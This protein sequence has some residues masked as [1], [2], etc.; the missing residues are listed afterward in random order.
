MIYGVQARAGRAA[1][2]ADRHRDKWVAFALSLAVPGAGQLWAGRASCLAD[3]ALAAGLIAGAAIG[4]P[5]WVYR[6]GFVLLAILSAERAKRAL[7]VVP[8]ERPGPRPRAVVAD[9][10]APGRGIDLLITLDLARPAEEVWDAMADPTRF[11]TIDPFHSRVIVMEGS[12]RPGAAIVLEHRAFG[13][14]FHRF[15]KLLSWREGN[16]Y[17]FSDLSA[18]GRDGF[19]PHVFTFAVEPTTPGRSRLT[20]RVRG[21]WTSTRLP[22]SLGRVWFRFV[23]REH[24]RMLSKA[25][26]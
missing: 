2:E 8:R 5:G 15:G 14:R 12:L 3:F 16:G 1:S 18:R 6:L 24:A 13:V 10:E 9:R 23:S 22:R 17:A 21:L 7:E 19:F 11:V 26:A 4:S 20:I 25:L